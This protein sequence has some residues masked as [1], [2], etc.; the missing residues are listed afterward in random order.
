MPPVADGVGA[1]DAEI[2]GVT[3]DRPASRA[4]LA[5]RPGTP[6]DQAPLMS[7]A[8]SGTTCHT[9]PMPLPAADSG[10]APLKV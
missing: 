8:E 9:P 3:L 5:D 4:R 7:L 2:L 6:D 10:L 1:A